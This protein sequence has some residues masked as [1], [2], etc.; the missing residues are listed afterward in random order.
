MQIHS[1]ILLIYYVAFR[2]NRNKDEVHTAD[3]EQQKLQGWALL[4]H[5]PEHRKK[6]NA[7]VYTASS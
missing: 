3:P 2:S 5:N 4:S 1:V 7:V 6:D